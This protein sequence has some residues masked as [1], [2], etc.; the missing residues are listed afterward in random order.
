M[1]ILVK[2]NR[3]NLHF[4]HVAEGT[5]ALKPG[6][7]KLDDEALWAKAKA[8]P[9]VKPMLEDETIVEVKGEKGKTESLSDFTE[10]K[11]IKLVNE[12][13]D[14]ALLEEWKASEQRA[15]VLLAISGQLDKIDPTKEKPEEEKA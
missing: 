15:K 14:K 8:H 5:V 1:A 3:P 13:I 10:A 6:V 2:Y 7:N 12:T 9:L 4:I 11:A